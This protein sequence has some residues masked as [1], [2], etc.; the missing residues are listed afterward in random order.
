MRVIGY[1]RVTPTINAP[2]GLGLAAQRRA[3]ED[4]ALA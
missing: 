3:I 4:R 2:R 1:S